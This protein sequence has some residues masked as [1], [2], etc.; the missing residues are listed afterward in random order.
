MLSRVLTFFGILVLSTLPLFAETRDFESLDAKVSKLE[1]QSSL[2][3]LVTALGALAHTDW[4]R[5]RADYDW[6][7]M[8]IA[9]DTSSYFQGTPTAIDAEGVFKSG[10]SVCQGYADLFLVIAQGL[11]IECQVVIGYA[12]GLGY[13]K[14]LKFPSV[15][16][17]WNVVNLDGGWHLV[18]ATW[19]SGGVDSSRNFVREFH[20]VWFDMNPKA[21]VLHHFPEESKWLLFNSPMT[22]GD[23]ERAPFVEVQT[24]DRMVVAGLD[25][26][27][28]LDLSKV[29]RFSD[30]DGYSIKSL[31]SM[32]G[33]L[34]QAVAMMKDGGMPLIEDGGDWYTVHLLEYPVR[35]RLKVGDTYHFAMEV[36]ILNFPYFT[37]K[38]AFTSSKVYKLLKRNGD[39]YT[40]D[41]T[42]K[43][44]DIGDPI[45]VVMLTRTKQNEDGYQ[46]IARWNA[47]E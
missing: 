11:G 24:L 5:A 4:E 20:E 46:I 30:H 36:K 12:K 10:K 26:G 25:G 34:P 33:S 45:N 7:A 2:K 18:D 35:G 23:Y 39:K 40:G 17:A 41:I 3:S 27:D 43:E 15:N 8:N 6:V 19:G 31:V 21:F 32:G 16:H 14:A 47:R 37:G 28:I 42:I 38:V 13:G 29:Y 9:Y 1:K 22:L 44:S